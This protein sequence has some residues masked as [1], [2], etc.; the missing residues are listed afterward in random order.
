MPNYNKAIIYTIK[1]DDININLIYVGSTC[2]YNKRKFDHKAK[3]NNENS[4]GYNNPKYKIIRANGGWNNFTM[5]PYKKFPCNDKIE[6]NIEEESCR[7]LLNANMNSYK[8]YSELKGAD[9]KKQYNKQYKIE[10]IEKINKKNTCVCGGKY[11]TNNK[12]KH[13]KSIKHKKFINL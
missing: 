11:T 7:V 5:Q 6:L 1:C 9:Y 2:N 13:L 12:S 10:N 3:C 4:K 8:C